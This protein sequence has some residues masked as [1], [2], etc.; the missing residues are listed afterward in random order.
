[1]SR[2]NSSARALTVGQ[3]PETRAAY[4]RKYIR[5]RKHRR[6][7]RLIEMLG[8]KC[9]RCGAAEGL[10]FDHIDPATKRFAICADLSR[11]WAD[12]LEEAAK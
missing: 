5:A 3:V 7:V 4:M 9:V 2:S 12:L 11:A 8:G 10:E 1:M 6:R